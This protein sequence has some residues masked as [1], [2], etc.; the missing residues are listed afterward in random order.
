M[1]LIL[2][3]GNLPHCR[4]FFSVSDLGIHIA[5]D[6]RV[7]VVAVVAAVACVVDGADVF[8]PHGQVGPFWQN[9]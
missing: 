7:V 5:D 8:V 9:F 1:F 6:D 2:F 3:T 4:F